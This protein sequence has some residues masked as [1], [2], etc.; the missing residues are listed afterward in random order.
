MVILGAKGLAKEL[1]TV[2]QWNGSLAN[3]VFFDNINSDVPDILYGRFPVLKSWQ[4]LEVHFQKSSCDFVLGVSGSN[5]RQNFTEK[6]TLVGGNLCSIVSNHALIGEFGN[7]I[8]NGIC[9]LS[10]ATI[11]TDITI[12]HGSV[13]NKAVI[14]SHDVKIGCYCEISPGAKILGR[15]TVGDRTHIGANAIILPDVIV[16]SD[17]KIGAGAV[18]T[19]HVPDGLTVAGVPAKPLNDYCVLYADLAYSAG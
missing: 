12:G 8:G 19:K 11:T 13:I 2:F 18:V 4:Q 6:A 15:A 17:C 1:L 9:I 10:Q 3:L 7:T 5:N 14:I 16:G